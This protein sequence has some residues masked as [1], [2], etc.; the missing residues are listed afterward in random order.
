MSEPDHTTSPEPETE[1]GHWQ[2]IRDV[3]AFQF[4]LA[5]DGLRDLL[6]SPASMV[7]ALLG[8][9][10]R[11]KDPGVYFRKLMRFGKQSDRWI[12]LFGAETHYHK[13]ETSSDTYVRKVEDL[14]VNE[15]HKGGVVRSVKDRTDALLGRLGKNEEED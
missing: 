15:Y 2:L 13:D 8:L 10:S 5:A 14:I 12:N 11:P 1:S 3:I 9:F 7:A 6:L 4:K